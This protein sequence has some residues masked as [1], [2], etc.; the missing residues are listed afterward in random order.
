MHLLEEALTLLPEADSELRAR[1]LAQLG[2]VLYFSPGTEHD[3]G[4]GRGGDGAPVGDDDALGD[5][6][7]SAQFAFW[8]PGMARTRLEFADELVVVTE[9]IG[10]A[11]RVAEAVIWRLG[12]HLTLGR[13]EAVDADA[14]RFLR[15][16][17]SGSTNP[18]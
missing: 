9:R 7:S 4:R 16:S 17:P 3:L 11:E 14:A 12:A 5:A 8:R 6:L 15:D 18:S 2:A 1:L 13:L 10:Q